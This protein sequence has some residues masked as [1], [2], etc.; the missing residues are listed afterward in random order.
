MHHI[1][2]AI[3]SWVLIG[4][5]F[6]CPPAHSQQATGA[7]PMEEVVV[8]ATRDTEE[9]RSVPAN[10][11]VI[12]AKDIEE[13][14]AT[15]LVEVL[16]KLESIQVRTYSGNPSQATIDL[17]GFGGDNPSG[18]TL[19]LL[20][21]KRLNNPD[22]NS[23][24]WL[25]ISLSNIEKVEV[26]RG[27]GSVLYGDS[28]IAGVINVITKKGEGKPEVSASVI[29]GSYGLHDEQV[30]IRGSQGKVSYALNGENSGMQGYRDRSTYTSRGAGLNLGYSGGEFW[31]AS[32]A[33]VL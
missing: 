22:M 8:T 7:V 3:L 13:S 6:F 14:G 25:Q 24:N 23:I 10:V 30:G 16:Q 18:K 4:W 33:L 27:A 31:N 32:F 15:S 17:R 21:G 1:S 19:V 5:L 11:S 9:V 2:A 28:A 20:D 26:I 29:G 12:T